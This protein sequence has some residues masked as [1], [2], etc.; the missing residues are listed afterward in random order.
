MLL[1][2]PFVLHY[3]YEFLGAGVRPPDSRTEKMEKVKFADAAIDSA[4]TFATALLAFIDDGRM[5]TKMPL[6][7]YVRH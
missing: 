2:R 4:T 1:T 5:P 7:V 3:L 6:L